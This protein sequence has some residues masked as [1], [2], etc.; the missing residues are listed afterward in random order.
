M[1]GEVDNEY[2]LNDG[3]HG[4]Y[5]REIVDVRDFVCTGPNTWLSPYREV[6]GDPMIVGNI[7]MLR[8]LA[9]KGILEYHA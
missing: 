3:G 6:R 4:S 7:G 9:K 1:R 2:I 8:L 5:I